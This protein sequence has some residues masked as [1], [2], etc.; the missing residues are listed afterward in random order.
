MKQVYKIDS[1]GFYVEPVILSESEV[2]PSDCVEVIPTEG[3]FKAK[4]NGIA[5]E[6]GAVIDHLAIAKESKMAE[7]DAKCKESILG[8]FKAT[9]DTVEYSFSND[10]EAQSNFKD[11]MW[12]LEN[13]KVT[14]VKWTAFD[15][16]G[17]IVRLDLDL[18]KLSDVNVARLTH[19]QTM[20][21]KY[22][23]ILQPKVESVTITTTIEDAIAEVE[24]IVW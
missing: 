13:N 15:S 20:V 17:N 8:Y 6:E 14:T 10:M 7:L 3:L 12:A 1:K 16:S 9:V 24:A 5:W 18:I 21:A 2:L 23:D 11:G 22:R 4:W 19:Q